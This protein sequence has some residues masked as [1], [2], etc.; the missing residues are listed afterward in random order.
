MCNCKTKD[1]LVNAINY[2]AELKE[3]ESEEE[4]VD[5][6]KSIIGMTDTDLKEF[7]VV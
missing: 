5:F 7:G 1:M 3:R 4:R 2:I 6:F